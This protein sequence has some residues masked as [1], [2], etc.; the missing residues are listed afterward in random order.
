LINVGN[1]R[2]CD[3]ISIS[4]EP[5]RHIYSFY[6]RLPENI[7]PTFASNCASITYALG[8]YITRYHGSRWVRI[9]QI[10]VRPIT[11]EKYLNINSDL[12]LLQPF[13]TEIEEKKMFSFL[14]NKKNN[15]DQHLSYLM[16]IPKI[17]FTCG[18][19]LP[20]KICTRKDEGVKNIEVSLIKKIK[21]NTG[22]I[23]K[24]A[25]QILSTVNLELDDN[26]CEGRF[27]LPTELIPTFKAG[28]VQGLQPY[29]VITLIYVIKVIDVFFK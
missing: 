18:E 15:S 7:P 21:Y 22:G 25:N 9:Y 27:R 5:G 12:S 24:T 19:F 26:I 8:A 11:I 16:D 13:H 1:F 4:L 23:M 14:F 28:H 2:C 10:K 6:F 20:F 17:G 29:D 3:V